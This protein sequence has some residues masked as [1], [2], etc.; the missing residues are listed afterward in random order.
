MSFGLKNAPGT[1]QRVT[2]VIIT[3]VKGQYALVHMDDVIIFSSEVESHFMHVDTGLLLI[4]LV[5]LTH[6]LRDSLFFHVIVDYLGHL[7]HQVKLFVAPRT[8][9]ATKRA[10]NPPR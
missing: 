7:I 4:R 8:I 5:G 3:K 6:K 2:D 1:I 9:H 10:Q